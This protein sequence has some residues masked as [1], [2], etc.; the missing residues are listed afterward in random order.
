MLLCSIFMYAIVSFLE[1]TNLTQ[2]VTKADDGDIAGF[3]VY[4]R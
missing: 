4:Q 1:E 3:D 2:N